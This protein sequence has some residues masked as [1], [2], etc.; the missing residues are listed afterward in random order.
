MI[1]ES[2]VISNGNVSISHPLLQGRR[3]GSKLPTIRLTDIGK[4]KP[5]GAT[6]AEVVD[7]VMDALEKQVASAVGA[8]GIDNMLKGLTRDAEGI[9]RGVTEG[10]AKSVEDAARGAGDTLKNLFGK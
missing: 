7:K 8:S 1:V 6:P 5:G 10:G 4:D 3:V 2:L 9:V